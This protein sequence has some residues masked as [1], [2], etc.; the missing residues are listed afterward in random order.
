MESSTHKKFVFFFGGLLANN[1]LAHYLHLLF[2]DECGPRT[3]RL[4]NLSKMN[5]QNELAQN[6]HHHNPGGKEVYV[7]IE[8]QLTLL[9]P[10]VTK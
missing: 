7:E 3:D 8:E 5:S 10:K 1:K 4:S 6:W 2:G 9:F